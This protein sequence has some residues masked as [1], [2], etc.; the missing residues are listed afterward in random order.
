MLATGAYDKALVDYNAAIRADPNE[1]TSWM[2]RGHIWLLKA[3]Y[4][5]LLADCSEAIRL[6]P[7]NANAFV[8]QGHAWSGKGEFDRAIASYSK[9]IELDAASTSAYLHRGFAWKEKGQV[10]KAIADLTKAISLCGEEI[11][12]SPEDGTEFRRRADAWKALGDCENAVWAEA[13]YDRAISDYEAV[14]RLAPK[15]ALAYCGYGDARK[16]KREFEKA[17]EAYNRAVDIRDVAPDGKLA[18][19]WNSRA[20]LAAT[21]PNAKYRNPKQAVEDAKKACELSGWND[22]Y[23]LDV[24]AAAYAE[25][26]DFANAVQWQTKAIERISP[27]AKTKLAQRLDLYEHHK[28]YREAMKN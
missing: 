22:S 6:Q 7:D 8:G 5:R 18:T 25:T 28:P 3:D 24:L 27:A 9:A 1:A 20:W 4:D 16:A 10:D 2:N 26:G 12:R 21:C 17:L 14:I 13:D 19:A 23:S 15:D 11:E